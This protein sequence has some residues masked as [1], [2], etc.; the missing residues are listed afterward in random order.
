MEI[1]LVIPTHR[2]VL[3]EDE[4]IR[5]SINR[6]MNPL[7]IFVLPQS[8]AESFVRKNKI[9]DQVIALP[10]YHF[11]SRM[12]YNKLLLSISFWQNFS[13]FDQILICQTDAV[14]INSIVDLVDLK[15]PFVGAPWLHKKHCVEFR[16]NLYVDY[17]KFFFVKGLKIPMGNGG[18]SLRR[19][20]EAINVLSKVLVEPRKYNFLDGTINEDLVFSYLFAK[21]KFQLPDSKTALSYFVEEHATY[22]DSIPEVKGFHALKRFNPSLEREILVRFSNFLN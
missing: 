6:K 13:S 20:I 17:R 10:D 1:P 21:F 18:L 4:L 19:P 9:K 15:Y 16:S 7:V 2:P 22:M 14:L 8:V 12:S 5:L 11:Y 3:Q